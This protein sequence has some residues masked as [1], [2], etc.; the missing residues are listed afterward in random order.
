MWWKKG[1]WQ[2]GVVEEDRVAVADRRRVEGAMLNVC[3][4][5]SLDPRERRPREGEE[6][7]GEEVGDQWNCATAVDSLGGLRDLEA[8][9]CVEGS[10]SCHAE[11]HGVAR[12]V[13][14]SV[15]VGNQRCMQT[16]Q[17]TLG[18]F[19]KFGVSGIQDWIAGGK[20]WSAQCRFIN[21]CSLPSADCRTWPL[22]V[23]F[24]SRLLSSLS[25]H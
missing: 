23:K 1:T 24:G 21:L 4:A 6:A 17:H 12:G 8:M 14:Y 11:M 18:S 22:H 5:G 9:T 13:W 19:V 7:G 16:R 3:F 10:I 15:N 25:L 20:S 2:A